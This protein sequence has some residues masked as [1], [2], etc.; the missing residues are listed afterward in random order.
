MNYKRKFLITPFRERVV[1][2]GKILKI[3]GDK[4]DF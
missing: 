3:W 2:G 1:G 4:N